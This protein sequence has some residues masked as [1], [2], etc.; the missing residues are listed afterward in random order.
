MHKQAVLMG[1]LSQY[2]IYQFRKGSKGPS[3]L[4]QLTCV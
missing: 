1:I 2:N 3:C 4:L